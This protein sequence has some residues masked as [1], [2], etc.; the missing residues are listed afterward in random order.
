MLKVEEIDDVEGGAVKTLEEAAAPLLPGTVPVVVF[1]K[2]DVV[3]GKGGTALHSGAAPAVG[4]EGSFERVSARLDASALCVGVGHPS[5]LA[6]KP[7]VLCRP[8]ERPLDE[9]IAETS[10][11]MVI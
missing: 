11:V 1:D 7:T 4:G 2:S 5:T 3:L 9:A 6:G 8:I 10:M